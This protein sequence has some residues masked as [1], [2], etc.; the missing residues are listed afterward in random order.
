MRAPGAWCLKKAKKKINERK[1]RKRKVRERERERDDD[2]DETRAIIGRD[3]YSQPK[4]ADVGPRCDSS[5]GRS[6]LDTPKENELKMKI[7]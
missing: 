3:T 6:R 4:N 7:K 2:D 5:V 1:K